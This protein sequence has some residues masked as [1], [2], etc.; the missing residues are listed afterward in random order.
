MPLNG[1]DALAV[2]SELRE[3]MA[4]MESTTRHMA[5][6]LDNVLSEARRTNGRITKIETERTVEAAADAVRIADAVAERTNRA[7][8]VAPAITGI[9][10]TT[11]STLVLMVLRVFGVL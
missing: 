9:A 2:L 8:W 11:G 4:S 5:T 1:D 10:A 7:T 6:T 3:R